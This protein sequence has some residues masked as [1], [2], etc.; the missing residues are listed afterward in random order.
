MLACRPRSLRVL[1]GS[2]ATMPHR[3]C[4]KSLPYKTTCALSGSFLEARSSIAGWATAQGDL[5]VNAARSD[6]RQKSAEPGQARTGSDKFQSFSL[7]NVKLDVVD[8]AKVA[9]KKAVI[10]WLNERRRP[11]L[12]SGA[13]CGVINRF[14]T[15][16]K[17]VQNEWARNNVQ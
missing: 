12:L 16:L 10:A 17:E 8:A 13:G 5:R 6:W 2:L 14:W 15:I 3:S 1:R 9:P 7:V 11:K 4:I